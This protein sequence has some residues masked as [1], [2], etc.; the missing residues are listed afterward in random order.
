VARQKKPYHHGDL[1][2]AL[3]TAALAA[4][5]EDGP[6]GFTLRDVAQRAGVSV[7]AP[8]RHFK[9]KDALL[10]E[11]AAECALRLGAAM[12]AAVAAASSD[13]LERFRATG[14]AY[15][16][17]AVEHPAHFRAVCLPGI[18]RH[19][20]DEVREGV[21]AWKGAER[22]RL[23]AAHARGQIGGGPIENVLLAAN[24]LVHGLA[25][26]IVDGQIPA[27]HGERLAWAITDVFG[28]GIVPR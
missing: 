26:M 12:D 14:I 13:P 25:S 28:Q 3:I 2:R 19:L 11:V 1:R 16:R 20:P 21:E 9:D 18:L 4:V 22:A 5:A 24:C 27:E 17:F 6:E 8:Y 10:A 23:T 7:A 15:V